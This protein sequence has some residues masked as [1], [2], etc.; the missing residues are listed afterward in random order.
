[1]VQTC[2]GRLANRL[3]ANLGNMD[4]HM[5]IHIY[6]ICIY[7]YNGCPLYIY[8]C[9]VTPCL[10]NKRTLSSLYVER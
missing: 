9:M 6:T 5:Y 8:I 2:M 1:M 10:Y 7:I 4:I 3:R